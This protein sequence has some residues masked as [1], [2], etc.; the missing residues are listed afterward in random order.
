MCACALQCAHAHAYKWARRPVQSS[1][2]MVTWTRHALVCAHCL[3]SCAHKRVQLLHMSESKDKHSLSAC[4]PA[5]PVI[6]V[7]GNVQTAAEEL[8][9]HERQTRWLALSFDG[10]I[11][12]SRR[13]QLRSFL[14]CFS[15][16]TRLKISKWSLQWIIVVMLSFIIVTF[17]HQFFVFVFSGPHSVSVWYWEVLHN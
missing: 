10:L 4:L 15:F 16:K 11:S 12:N 9:T 14:F 2:A 1:A 13:V 5:A 7:D 8:L 3:R 6:D 17:L